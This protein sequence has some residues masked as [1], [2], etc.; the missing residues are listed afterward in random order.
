MAIPVIS[1]ISPATGPTAG[2][3][4]AR[5]SG[6]G[7]A[8]QVEVLFGEAPGEVLSV[9]EE[10]GVSLADVRTPTHAEASV[11]VTLRNLDSSGIPVLGEEIV[12]TPPEDLAQGLRSF[13]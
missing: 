4:L 5:I 7:F 13:W 2:G 9:R 11:D 10:A 6:S 3:D 12:L 8:A 1:G